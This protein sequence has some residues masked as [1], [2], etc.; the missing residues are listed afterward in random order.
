MF[1]DDDLVTKEFTAEGQTFTETAPIV[2]RT[3]G[4]ERLLSQRAFLN[5]LFRDNGSLD[6]HIDMF[7]EYIKSVDGEYATIE[8]QEISWLYEDGEFQPLLR[9][10]LKDLADQSS[11]AKDAHITLSTV[12]DGRRFLTLQ[13]A[14]DGNYEEEDMWNYFRIMGEPYI[15]EVPWA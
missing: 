12:I 13:D 7:S 6:H 15:R 11:K 14:E 9:G 4:V 1:T 10:C 3:A 5:D 2:S 8:L